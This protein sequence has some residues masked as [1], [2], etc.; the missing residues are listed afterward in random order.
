VDRAIG[1]KRRKKTMKN[2]I[3]NEEFRYRKKSGEERVGL[4][5]TSII[6]LEGEKSILS[7]IRD[8]TEL[9][10]IEKE[11]T[12]LERLN[13][14]GEMAAGIGHEIRNP[15]TTVR[16]FLQMLR[17]KQCCTGYKE[18]F[19]VMIEELDRANYIITEFLTL[20]KNKPVDLE[21]KNLNSI[22]R[23]LSPLITADAA[24]KSI[25]VEM[26]LEDTP[27]FLLNQKEIRQLVLN[28]V[29]NGLE[30]MSS[31]GLLTIRTY[32]EG[33][34][35]ILSVQDQGKGIS[36]ELLDRLGTPFFTTKDTGT[37]LGLAICYSI[38]ARHGAAIKI[39][40]GSGGTTFKVRFNPNQPQNSPDN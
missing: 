32:T 40:T 23:A 33:D 30:A 37:G 21:I 16:G 19:D 27:D 28:L 38:T 36:P 7:E 3:W 22:I 5:S 39:K 2:S 20:A 18:Y 26:A 17:N 1:E 6:D 11:M 13:L 24:N 12:R 25:N 31:G 14:I 35:V 10:R 15:M 29:R 8:I 9:K 4:I 34:L